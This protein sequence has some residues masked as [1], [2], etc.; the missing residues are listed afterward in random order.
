MKECICDNCG[1][2]FTVEKFDTYQDL[3]KGGH[4]VEVISFTCPKCDE[5]Y[6]VTVRDEKSAQLRDEYQAAQ[7]KY[8][9][10]YD[11]ADKDKMRIAKNEMNYAKRSLM[12]YMSQLKKKYIKE[13]RRRGE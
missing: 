10:S 9:G 12:N 13:L 6:I 7:A 11:P 4:K 3:L 8:R 2:S 5:R 1:M